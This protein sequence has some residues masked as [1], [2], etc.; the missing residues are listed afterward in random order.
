MIVVVIM[1]LLVFLGMPVAFSLGVSGLLFFHFNAVPFGTFA[2]KL[3]ES[4]NSFS[5]LAL[6]FFILAGNIMNNGGIT[7]RLFR[8][9]DDS[10][11]SVRGGLS[12]VSIVSGALFSAMSG[13]AIANAAGLGS[14][15]IDAMEDRGYDKKFCG[16]LVA[17]VSILGP[18]IPP[19]M[20]MIVYAVT[21][22]T[23]VK[24][25]FMGGILPGLLLCLIYVGLSIYYGRKLEFPR[26]E[27]FN[28]R[29]FLSSLYHSIGAL[30]APVI[31]LGGIF[32]GVFTAT[33]S[34]AIACVY[35]IIVGFIYGDLSLK[36]LLKVLLKSARDTGNILF[37]TATGALFG[38]CLAYARVPQALATWLTSFVSSKYVLLLILTFVYLI[39]G[40]LMTPTAIVITTVPIFIPLCKALNIDLVYFGVLTGILMCVGTITP[41]V[42][43]VMFIICKK[44]GISIEE[45]T[46]IM[47]PWY[48]GIF[49]FLLMLIFIPQII[50]F[51][52]ELLA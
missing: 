52:P 44:I 30:L 37:I 13:S 23:S 17:A 24:S 11:G 1:L 27:K 40:C 49:V 22:G 14:I 29:R 32:S 25:M 43:T 21:A 51:L 28:F 35:S 38:F 19:S 31:I 16:A 8:L 20:I 18:I 10:L 47:L 9:A 12:Y 33:E 4:V 3:A 39:L 41:P 46:R 34:G 15:Q 6:P 26:G 7:K 5:T 42:G 50:T 45:F 36:N 2:Q 48:I